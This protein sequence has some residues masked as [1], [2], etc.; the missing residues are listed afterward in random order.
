MDSHI[1]NFIF[2]LP[3]PLVFNLGKLERESDFWFLDMGFHKQICEANVQFLKYE[4]EF[5][6]LSKDLLDLGKTLIFGL[7]DI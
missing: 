7:K 3:T 2:P 6:W 1:G 5:E 4:R